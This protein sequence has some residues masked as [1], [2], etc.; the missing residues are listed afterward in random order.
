LFLFLT[1]DNKIFF[2]FNFQK[3]K[4]NQENDR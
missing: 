4:Q 3:K 1:N 2:N